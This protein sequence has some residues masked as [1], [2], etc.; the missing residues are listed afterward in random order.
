MLGRCS[1]TAYRPGMVGP[2]DQRLSAWVRAWADEYAHD[3]DE[4]FADLWER[5]RLDRSSM[6]RLVES[7]DLVPC[8]V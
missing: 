2:D 1:A 6:E 4:R 7:R 5:E 3:H 8:H